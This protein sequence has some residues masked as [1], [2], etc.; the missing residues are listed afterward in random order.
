MIQ[1]IAQ[2]T[3]ELLLKVLLDKHS[4]LHSCVAVGTPKPLSLAY[5]KDDKY[6]GGITGSIFYERLHIK[7][8]GVDEAYRGQGIGSELVSAAIAF[9]KENGC[10]SI[11]VSTLDYQGPK[12]YEHLG[13]QEYAILENVPAKGLNTHYFVMYL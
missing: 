2:E 9:A 7:L 13:F 1:K 12:F 5:R 6:V 11:T 4:E 8:L 10:T 3:N